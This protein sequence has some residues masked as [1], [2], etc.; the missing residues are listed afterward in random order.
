MFT[1]LYNELGSV[2]K[3]AQLTAFIHAG[4]ATGQFIKLNLI[5]EGN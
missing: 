4:G 3:P 2:Y 1:R 5:I